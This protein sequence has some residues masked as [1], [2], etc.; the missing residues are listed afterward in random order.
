[1]NTYHPIESANKPPIREHLTQ[2][3]PVTSSNLYYCTEEDGYQWTCV[4]SARPKLACNHGSLDPGPLPDWVRFLL[5][6]VE[7][8]IR[9]VSSL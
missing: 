1:M 6:A 9:P 7:I 5:S 4:T 8:A 2:N 3:E